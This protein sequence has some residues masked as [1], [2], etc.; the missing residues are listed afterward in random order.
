MSVVVYYNFHYGQII[1]ENHNFPQAI[2]FILFV[3]GEM[4]GIVYTF[5]FLKNATSN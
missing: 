1:F 5:K 2:G 3:L 4:Y